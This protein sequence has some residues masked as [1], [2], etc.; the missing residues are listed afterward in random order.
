MAKV[1]VYLTFNGQ[2][3]AAFN[4]YKSVFGG[5]FDGLYRFRDM[6]DAGFPIPE[7]IRDQ[8]MHVGLPVSGDTALYGSDSFDDG[9][10]HQLVQ[11]NN[12]T[13]CVNSQ[14]ADESRRIFEA[15]SVNGTVRMPL[16]ETFWSPLY[17][18]VCDQFG[19]EWMVNY[20]PLQED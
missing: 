8:V 18:L 2:C 11:G 14:S 6:P 19:I 3:E 9:A 7:A 20:E 5:E 4:F 16:A 17:G 12:V 13:I 15:L 1:N 10:G